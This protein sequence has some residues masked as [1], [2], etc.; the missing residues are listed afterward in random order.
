MMDVKLIPDD[1]KQRAFTAGMFDGLI[2]L[3]DTRFHLDFHTAFPSGPARP[4]GIARK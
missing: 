2:Y 4:H 1:P 3:V